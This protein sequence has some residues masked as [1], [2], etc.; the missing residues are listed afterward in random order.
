MA[1]VIKKIENS[2]PVAAL[3][4]ML[5]SSLAEGFKMVQVLIDDWNN[6]TNTFSKPGEAFFIA[7]ADGKVV[8]M[9]GR[10]I[11]PYLNDQNVARVRR[12]YVLP[13]FRRKSV[14]RMLMKSIMDVPP[15]TFTCFTLWTG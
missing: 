12:L 10:N 13:A 8:G 2:L 4:E 1:V 9:G 5:E 3:G 7:E 6:S 15:G 11:D 14:G